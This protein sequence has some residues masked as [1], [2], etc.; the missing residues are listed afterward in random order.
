MLGRFSTGGESIC[1]RSSID[2]R[3]A[4]LLIDFLRSMLRVPS[5]RAVCERSAFFLASLT[6]HGRSPPLPTVLP[7]PCFR[8]LF[9]E[10]VLL[11]L[12]NDFVTLLVTAATVFLTSDIPFA[13][14]LFWL[15]SLDV[16]SLVNES[17]EGID[18]FNDDFNADGG[19]DSLSLSLVSDILFRMCAGSLSGAAGL[20]VILGAGRNCCGIKR[21]RR[22]GVSFSNLAETLSS[23]VDFLKT[24][25]TFDDVDSCCLLSRRH[26]T[27]R[28]LTAGPDEDFRNAARHPTGL[29]LNVESGGSGGGG[30][31]GGGGGAA[32]VVFDCSTIETG[33]DGSRGRGSAERG[34]GVPSGAADWRSC[35]DDWRRSIRPISSFCWCGSIGHGVFWF[36]P[37]EAM[38]SWRTSVVTLLDAVGFVID[39]AAVMSCPSPEAPLSDTLRWFNTESTC[40]K[41][42]GTIG[43]DSETFSS[44]VW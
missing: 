40:V 30:G 19:T 18:S 27:G 12:S 20:G 44:V 24:V 38:N 28:W 39:E 13:S 43:V 10:S 23:V 15:T 35:N 14:R 33:A 8:W 29:L 7:V 41:K 31:G 26:Q 1:R 4:A 42:S 3:R 37:P 34:E 2:L 22:P 9:S 36:S 32:G 21:P 25:D 16:D 11:S 17:L 5:I 6:F